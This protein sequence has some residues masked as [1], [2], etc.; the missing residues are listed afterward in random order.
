MVISESNVHHVKNIKIK[1]Q[2][3]FDETD[4]WILSLEIEQESQGSEGVFQINFYGDTR[5]SVTIKKV[6]ERKDEE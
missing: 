4:V 3:H 6:K 5:E 1:R 2:I